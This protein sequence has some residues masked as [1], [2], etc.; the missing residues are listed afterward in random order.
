[1]VTRIF[2]LWSKQIWLGVFFTC[3]VVFILNSRNIESLQKKQK[4]IKA[5]EELSHK[6]TYRNNRFSNNDNDAVYTRFINDSFPQLY[7]YSNDES[8]TDPKHIYKNRHQWWNDRD[9]STMPQKRRVA[10]VTTEIEGPVLGGGIGTAYTALSQKL[11]E[12]GHNVT[13]VLVNQVKKL[14]PTHWIQAYG[15]RGIRM[16]IL[17]FQNSFYAHPIGS[18][19]ENPNDIK[20]E[21]THLN[22]LGSVIGCTGPCIRAYKIYLWLCAHGEKD[23]DIIHFHDNGGM[24]YFSLKAKHQGLYFSRL[25]F[26]IGGHGPHL[27]ERTANSANLDDGKHFEVDYLERKSVEYSD[28]LISPS[29]YMLNWMK[30]NRWQLP[31]NSYVHQNLLPGQNQQEFFVEQNLESQRHD[32]N[33]IIFFGRLESR[34]GLDIFMKALESL[35]TMLRSTSTRITF[36]GS[37]TKLVEINTMADTYILNRCYRVLNITCS[38]LLGKSHTEAIDYLNNDKDK[39]LIVVASPIDNSPNTVLECLTHQLAIIST[40]VGGI[41]ELIHPQDRERVMFNPKAVALA[42][43][44]MYLKQVGVYSARFAIDEYTRQKIWSNWHSVVGLT[45]KK[46]T[47]A[48]T[49]NESIKKKLS[50]ILV[51]QKDNIDSIILNINVVKS[52]YQNSKHWDIQVVLATTHEY[53]FDLPDKLT[54]ELK[55][56]NTSNIPLRLVPINEYLL[57][58]FQPWNSKEI[59][60]HALG[61]FY[62]F[63]DPYDYLY[64]LHT[65]RILGVVQANTKSLLITSS[66]QYNNVTNG[67]LIAAAATSNAGAKQ[68]EKISSI[69]M[70]CSGL[71]GIMYNCFGSN[72]M[73]VHNEIVKEYSIFYSVEN[74]YYSEIEYGGNWE[75]YSRASS[76]G[77]NIEAIPKNLFISKKNDLDSPT[78]YNQELRVLKHI[79]N[80]LPN[81]F[82]LTPMATR[83]FLT[84]KR[85]YVN[86]ISAITQKSKEM[87]DKC[88]KVMGRGIDVKEQFRDFNENGEE[89]PYLENRNHIGL[90]FIRGHEKSGTSWL[91]KVVDLH[92]R[93]FM[94]PHEF[95][96]HMLEDGIEKFTKKPWAASKEPYFSYTRNWYRSFVRN[97]LLSGVSPTQAPLI[98]WAGEKTPSP[99]APIISG[100]KYILIVRDGRDVIVSL[101]WHF[102][103]LGGFENWCGPNQ[104]GLVDARY[105]SQY[106]N[107]TDYFHQHTSKLLEKEICFRLIARGWA[108]RVKEDKAVIQE[109]ESNPVSEVHM[110]VYEELHR[111]P[112]ENRRAIYEFLNLD[113]TEAEQLSVNDK[114]APGGFDEHSDKNKF[115]RKGEIGDWKNYFTPENKRWFKE[116]TGQLLVDL[117]YEINND[118]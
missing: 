78:T 28:W 77:I 23:F 35:T 67:E 108:K 38:V 114:T 54:E 100:S 58:P 11:K 112:E 42:K 52:A 40:N 79:D 62:L 88:Q 66:T 59:L 7:A 49:T 15:S 44:I 31:N 86:E 102:V 19:E 61:E 87:I 83:H 115:F 89:V 43:K 106:K 91:K 50:I 37:N 94:A 4:E 2:R 36:L 12:D 84:S 72:N 39:K 17:D 117:G 8:N 29:Q 13:I 22:D 98:N 14:S 109:L 111:N 10:I 103:R 85:G 21:I 107:N 68:H 69:F 57:Q 93:I 110:V 96:F 18:I 104:S 20:V 48:V 73:L 71:S 92:P 80:V 56:L 51:Y 95:H 32:F 116:E 90:V 65:L 27:W 33:E 76:Q 47:A 64:N 26:V 30:Y 34:K 46:A 63:I 82:D 70:G 6:S 74:D 9:P 45:K 1:M 101:F 25:L 99:L 55:S 118:W 16:V 41:P 60:E 113:Y 75:F 105:V 3:L 97:L 24:A 5:Q 81:N 53:L